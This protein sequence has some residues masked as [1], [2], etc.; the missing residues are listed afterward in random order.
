MGFGK[1]ALNS[2]YSLGIGLEWFDR[3]YFKQHSGVN[4]VQIV[5]STGPQMDHPLQAGGKGIDVFF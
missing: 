1:R 3:R 4:K 2:D 5:D